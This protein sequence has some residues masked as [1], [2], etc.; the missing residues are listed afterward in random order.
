MADDTDTRPL[1]NAEIAYIVSFCVRSVYDKYSA[2]LWEQNPLLGILYVGG[3]T[4]DCSYHGVY[5]N[6]RMLAKQ[7]RTISVSSYS[8]DL[9]EIACTVCSRFRFCDIENG[10]YVGITLGS[11]FGQPYTQL[12]LNV[13]HDPGS[14]TSSNDLAMAKEIMQCSIPR[15]PLL[16]GT[17]RNEYCDSLLKKSPS[18]NPE[19]VIARDAYKRIPSPTLRTLAEDYHIFELK[20]VEFQHDRDIRQKWDEWLH[21]VFLKTSDT[22]SVLPPLSLWDKDRIELSSTVIRFQWD[23]RKLKM[24]DIP[25]VLIESLLGSQFQNLH[26]SAKGN[27]EGMGKQKSKKNAKTGTQKRKS[28]KSNSGAAV[29]VIR[30]DNESTNIS[31]NTSD[32]QQDSPVGP[33]QPEL[34]FLVLSDGK[35][36]YTDIIV[37]VSNADDCPS[38]EL[39]TGELK[40]FCNVFVVSQWMNRLGKLAV[41]HP[42]P[43]TLH[44]K[45]SP[46]SKFCEAV[47]GETPASNVART[48][49]VGPMSV[50]AVSEKKENGQ[51]RQFRFTANSSDMAGAM[52][53]PLIDYRS[54]YTNNVRVIYAT[55]GIIAAKRFIHEA[56]LEITCKAGSTSISPVHPRLLASIMCAKEFVVRVT[57]SSIASSLSGGFSS[58]ST[59]SKPG[60]IFHNAALACKTENAEMMSTSNMVGQKPYGSR[61][62]N[63]NFGHRIRMRRANHL[64]KTRFMN[65]A[66]MPVFARQCG[67]DQW[68]AQR[69]HYRMNNTDDNDTSSDNRESV[70]SPSML[71]IQQDDGEVDLDL[72][73]I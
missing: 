46:Y 69:S 43:S 71:Q 44:D 72:L 68:F 8:C 35:Q 4:L 40:N 61:F 27:K 14:A 12:A 25:I 45:I 53:H 20:D 59:G 49:R 51:I 37:Y 7:L 33:F 52:R 47:S 13:F 63:T 67:M 28:R 6:R 24:Y 19:S 50:L 42:G 62:V 56:M 41:V 64:V 5:K 21:S 3:P 16:Y 65:A 1:T 57:H 55:L 58:A 18:Q 17:L 11:A 39:E 73:R 48:R 15:N 38:K 9:D 30:S 36:L 29:D 70:S 60:V 54:V 31:E 26:S 32:A 34:N 23:A 66:A 2:T 10:S 22:N